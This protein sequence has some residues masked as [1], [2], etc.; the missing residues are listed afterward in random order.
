MNS[1]SLLNVYKKFG[2]LVAVNDITMEIALGERRALIGPNGAG[3]TT[4]FNVIAGDLP[5][6]SGHILLFGQ[7]VTHMPVHKRVKLGLR[8]T[9]QTAA[10]CNNLT[11][12]QNIY[13]GVVGPQ[14]GHYD[15]IHDINRDNKYKDQIIGIARMINLTDQL[16][17]LAGELSH[18]ERRMLE[19][20]LA[21]AHKPKLIMLDEPAA[22]LSP[23]ERIKVKQ[24][25]CELPRE[26]TLFLIE[27]D[28]DIALS[29]SDHVTVL[30]EGKI[31]ADGTPNEIASNSL[32]Q[33]V[34]LGTIPN[35][36]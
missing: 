11:V 31:I 22:G 30:H 27:H 8:R 7:D 25:L 12:Y 32:V 26:I 15:M 16:Q 17:Y 2:G 5:A 18:G 3:K 33:E 19:F 1:L 21:I 34:Y 36:S 23:E 29:V 4:L 10:L 28:M 35:E 13:L 24:F 6:S 20:G 14:G 9:Y